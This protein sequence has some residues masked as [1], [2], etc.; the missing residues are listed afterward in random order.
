MVAY[1]DDL[2]ITGNDG[3]GIIALKKFLGEQFQITD[4]DKLKYFLGIEVLRSHDKL[5]IC[6]RKYVLDMLTDCGLL[7]C[8][9][10]DSPMVPEAKLMPEDGELLKD[11]E[12][13]CRLVGKL[14][15]LTITRP[16]ISYP[17]STVSQ[18]MMAPR[19]THWEAIAQILRY[20]KG[21]P[22]KG[23]V[24]RNHGHDNIVGF[25]DADWAGCPTS[26]RSTTGF[27][28]FFG[29]NLVS[30]KSEKHTI[31]ARSSVESEYRAMANTSCELV[32]TKRLLHELGVIH[33]D[34]MK[35]HCD[36]QAAMH[37]AKNQVFHERTKHIEVDCHIIRDLVIGTNSHPPCIQLVHVR[38]NLQLADILTKPLRKIH[39]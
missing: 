34:L 33:V 16:D 28:I 13:Y 36:N 26:R 30:W 6:Q 39:I 29:K 37:I 35:L 17:V 27:C 24:Y 12:R 21:V 18:F 7:G 4:L 2:I 20:L 15:Y 11:P 23:L 5:L 3:D 14:N 32:W 19:T 31:M 22:G 25:T 10:V 38:T 1:V 9:L 8:K